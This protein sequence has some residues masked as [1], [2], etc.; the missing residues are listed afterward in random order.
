MT[1][2][3]RL[4]IA[5]V[6]EL[7][8]RGEAGEKEAAKRA[9]DRLMKRYNIDDSEIERI[10]EK[11]YSFKY[12]LEIDKSLFL[13]LYDFFFPG[14]EFKPWLSTFGCREIQMKFEYLDYVL[15]SCAF[16][17]FKQHMNKEYK[18]IVLPQ[19]KRCRS[20]K[21]RNARRA[22]L[23]QLFFGR[24]IIASKLYRPE[25]LTTIDLSK[26]TQKELA[27]RAKMRGIEGGEYKT[28]L[29]TGLYL[30]DGN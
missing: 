17:Y 1:E 11:T 27:D 4:K 3:T 16:E 21:T 20:A 29:S 15:F 8:N 22:E 24:Y 6:Y 10:K 23:Q 26:L 30:G 18:K 14:K 9:L 25:D 19:L 28:Q 13:E 2:E 12:S 7:V 5:K